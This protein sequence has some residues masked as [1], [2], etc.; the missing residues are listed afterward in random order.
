MPDLLKKCSLLVSANSV[1][2]PLEAMCLGV[3]ILF[4]IPEEFSFGVDTFIKDNAFIAYEDNFSLKLEEALKANRYPKLKAED[5]FS[6]P[7]Y[8]VFLKYIKDKENNSMWSKE[9]IHSC[10]R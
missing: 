4:F 10:K 9:R 6:A 3:K 1:S 5:Y 7:D 2:V 8:T